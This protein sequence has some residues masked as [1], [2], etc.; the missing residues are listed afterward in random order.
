VCHDARVSEG[1]VDSAVAGAVGETLRAAGY[2]ASGIRQRFGTGVFAAYRNNGNTVPL[3]AALGDRTSLD[4]L[5]RL[6][7]LRLEV[8]ASRLADV[9]P[10]ESMQEMIAVKDGQARSLV[11]LIPWDSVAGDLY[12][13]SD[14]ARKEADAVDDH[15]LGVHPA[16]N[17]LADFVVRAPIRR[18]LDLGTGSGNQSLVLARH[19]DHLTLSDL[20]PRALRFARTTLDLNG[21]TA[22]ADFVLSDF[23]AAFGD[24]E[25]D[26]ITSNPPF[27]IGP[28]GRHIFRDAS[29]EGDDVSRRVIQDG[30]RRLAPG[31][32]LQTT[33]QWLHVRGE[34]WEARVRSWVEG[35]GCDAW[36]VQTEV[37]NTVAHALNWMVVPH[38]TPEEDVFRQWQESLAGADA[39]GFGVVL[40][41]RT[42]REP[43]IRIEGQRPPLSC[44]EAAAW[45]AG[46][47]ILR[48]PRLD[49]D[50]ATVRLRS[51]AYVRCDATDTVPSTLGLVNEADRASRFELPRATIRTLVRCDGRR[52]IGEIVGSGDGGDEEALRDTI[53]ELISAGILL[54]SAAAIGRPT[55]VL[56]RAVCG[57]TV[58]AHVPDDTTG[59]IARLLPGVVAAAEAAPDL[60]VHLVPN[61]GRTRPY[62]YPPDHPTHAPEDLLAVVNQIH[63]WVAA[64]ARERVLVK[65]AVAAWGT[66][67][68]VLTGEDAQLQLAIATA[69]CERGAILYSERFAVLDEHGAVESYLTGEVP[70][71]QYPAARALVFAS[72]SAGEGW[73]VLE[74][75]ATRSALALVANAP[76]A[77]VRSEDAL[78][79]VG[80]A[81]TGARAIE[82]SCGS[83]DE[84][85]SQLLQ[86]LAGVSA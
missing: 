56:R 44:L 40:L 54:S 9:L 37:R 19:A 25:F 43:V 20:N 76:V 27:V 82:G 5:I 14:I 78:A 81:L 65:A 64:N 41:R 59:E 29:G 12:V 35:L 31:G 26:L 22:P 63:D 18:A 69:L 16:A 3:A 71:A 13:V 68:I 32:L 66:D 48:A 8:P 10:V 49:F 55:T 21:V 62:A 42:E 83:A 1:L 74:R 79:A 50:A 77:Q 72:L 30:A 61:V 75:S 58:A 73:D 67:A 45:L 7:L 39:V 57:L 70:D 84:A 33:A 47:D 86:L 28:H 15:V 36:I 17:T 46:A 53:R 34:P 52:P 51:S 38:E 4:V 23:Y 80:A 6:F 85:A 60:T 24:R 2:T 11:D